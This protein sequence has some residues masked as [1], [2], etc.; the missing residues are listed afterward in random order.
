[1]G[2]PCLHIELSNK[3]LEMLKYSD[4]IPRTT[5]TFLYSATTWDVFLIQEKQRSQTNIKRLF[6]FITHLE[7][8]LI[9]SV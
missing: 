3:A 4:Y 6:E 8:K 5:K 9:V 7:P 1:M 2:L